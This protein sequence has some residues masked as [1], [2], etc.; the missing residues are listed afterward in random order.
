MTYKRPESVLVV[1]YSADGRV[2]LLRRTSPPDFWQSVTGSLAPGEGAHEAARRELYE[3]TGLDAE[4]LE[5]CG[6]CN[7]FAIL[8]AWR[9]R[10]RPG[11]A[12]NTEYVFRLGLQAPQ[13][14]VLDP[15]EHSEYRWVDKAVALALASSY[16]NRD[17]IRDYVPE[18]G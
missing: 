3:E 11:V 18:P 2:L 9:H 14:V 16:T 15:E 12:T 13:A 6:R 1:V 17:A 5:D 7:A 4:G 10:Y 8:P